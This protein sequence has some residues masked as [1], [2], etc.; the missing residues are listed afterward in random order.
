M[1]ANKRSRTNL[2]HLGKINRASMANK[3]GE[4]DILGNHILMM[5]LIHITGIN[6]QNH[7]SFVTLAVIPEQ[8]QSTHVHFSP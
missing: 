8:V 6:G 4:C 1:I 3:Y 7:Y 5:I 2:E